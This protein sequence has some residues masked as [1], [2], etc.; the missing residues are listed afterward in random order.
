M[1]R[2]SH[3]GYSRGSGGGTPKKNRAADPVSSEHSSEYDSDDDRPTLFGTVLRTAMAGAA[4]VAIAVL[5]K[6]ERDQ[7]NG[8]SPPAYARRTYPSYTTRKPS[9]G[10]GAGSAPS[11]SKPSP[12]KPASGGGGG[13]YQVQEGDTLYAIAV[14]HGVDPDTL[15]AMNPELAGRA[16]AIQVGEYVRV[17]RK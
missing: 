5:A 8:I 15:S 10:G 1:P 13:S 2:S 7:R 4:V 12:S 3:S 6:I 16:H 17:P 14:T 11:S 9:G